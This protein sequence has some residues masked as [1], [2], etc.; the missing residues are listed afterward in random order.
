[1]STE[2]NEHSSTNSRPFQIL[3]LNYVSLYLEDFYRGDRIL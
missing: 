2:M 3:D 1:M